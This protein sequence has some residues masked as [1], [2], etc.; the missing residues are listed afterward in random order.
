MAGNQGGK[1]NPASKRM[2]NKAKAAKRQ[3]SW[4]KNQKAKAI[5]IAEQKKREQANKEAKAMG[6]PTP[7]QIAAAERKAAKEAKK[8][9]SV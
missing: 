8:A 9:A 6:L 3:R 5:R 2:S 4:E 7:A 1:G